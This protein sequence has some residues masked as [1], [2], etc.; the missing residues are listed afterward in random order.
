[1]A[2]L[3]NGFIQRVKEATDLLELVGEYTELTP[4]GSNLWMANCPH[5]DH[6]DPTPSFRVCHNADGSWS[7]Y[8]GGCHMGPKNLHSKA[9][10]NVGSDC[11]AFLQW[12]SEY[13]GSKHVI[14]WRE[15]VEIL[16]KRAGIPMEEDKFDNTYKMLYAVA[17]R[18]HETL[19]SSSSALDYIHSRGITDKT[20]NEWQIGLMKNHEFGQTV[21][22]LSFP[23]FSRHNRVIGESARAIK[24]IKGESKF[25][26]YRNSSNSRIFNKSSYL[27]GLHRYTSDVPELR[28]TEGAMDVITASQ[29]GALNVVCTLGTAFTKEHIMEIK[30]LK[31]TPCFCLDGDAAGQ[32]GIKR[33]VAMLAEEGVYAKV[34][35]LPD[36]KDL[37]DLALELRED[38]EDYIELHSK[39]YWEYL[40]EEPISIYNAQLNKAREKILPLVMAASKGTTTPEDRMLMKNF[41]RERIGIQL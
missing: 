30:T 19:M 12:M 21:E 40:L 22:R 11:F 4:A 8:C 34:C 24:Y 15:S 27:Y 14:G 28:I 26:K 37:A 23:L 33:A 3:T 5:P 31:T 36:G 38:I 2:R 18:R 6:D 10:R 1:M 32:K 17:K 29:F 9:L 41:V 35:V 13:K 20:L 25:P 39:M 16:A 7:W